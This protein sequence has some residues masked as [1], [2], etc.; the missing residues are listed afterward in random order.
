[1]RTSFIPCPCSFNPNRLTMKAITSYLHGFATAAR[2]LRMIAWIYLGYLIIALLLAIPFFGLF[3]MA[4][5]NSLLPDSLLG[6]FDAT[7][8]REI[9]ADSG[10]AFAFYLEG[11]MPWIIAFLLFQVY[12]AGGSLSWISN[13]RGK[14]R[15]NGFHE[16][17]LKFYWRFL[18]L[19]FYFVII[20]IITALI[21]YV[22]YILVT[23]SQTGL[24]DEAVVRPL[25][26][27][28]AGHLILITFL[29]LWSDLVKSRLFEQDSRKVLKTMFRCL[30]MAVR[31]IFSFYFL[32]IILLLAP[33]ALF[34]GF[35]LLRSS[36]VADT[37]GL[38]IVLFLVQQLMIL[39]RV[40]LRIW[41][42]SSVY[43][44]YLQI[45][46]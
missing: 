19:T 4:A 44:F 35:Y 18:K 20:Q 36:M 13:P 40:Y 45:K 5:G 23:G 8:I 27:I 22:P 42:L 34:A 33:V 38:I 12:L 11:F 1:L 41:R 25:V 46:D 30:R 37:T 14:F 26:M 17:G 3:R 29:L 9:L 39:A 21:L 10:K 43:R 24:T 28:M 16:H 7:A 31:R 6:G 15:L 32:G 2:S